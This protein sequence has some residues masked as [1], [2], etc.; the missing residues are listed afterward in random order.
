MPFFGRRIGTFTAVGQV[1]PDRTP[2]RVRF[3]VPRQVSARALLR[4]R[5]LPVEVDSNEAGQ[6]TLGLQLRGRYV[7]FTFETRDIP[8]RF[9]FTHFAFTKRFKARI[10]AAVGAR[11]RLRIS[12]SDFKGN[13]RR[14]VRTVRLIR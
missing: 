8:G 5:R 6:V 3:W 13:S 7:G 11:L 1:A 9:R 10:R 4:Q 2:A 14:A 12:V